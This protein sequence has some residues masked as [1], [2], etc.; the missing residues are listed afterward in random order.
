MFCF[1]PLSRGLFPGSSNMITLRIRR[2]LIGVAFQQAEKNPAGSHSLFR[3]SG[4]SEVCGPRCGSAHITGP[5][6]E[7]RG[8]ADVVWQDRGSWLPTPPARVCSFFLPFPHGIS[9]SLQKWTFL[10]SCIAV[11]LLFR[12][13]RGVAWF[14]SCPIPSISCRALAVGTVLPS[15]GSQS[16]RGEK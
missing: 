15:R 14:W 3:W 4:M 6:K 5:L 11:A 16:N 10:F 13:M 12:Q 7:V 2:A 9:L 8:A 1:V